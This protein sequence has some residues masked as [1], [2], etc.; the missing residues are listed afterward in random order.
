MCCRLVARALAALLPSAKPVGWR[1]AGTRGASG[2]ERA[3]SADLCHSMSA[4]AVS[5]GRLRA[6]MSAACCLGRVEKYRPQK[7]SEV[8][9]NDDAVQR[10]R[11]IATD[12]NMPH[13]IL[14]VGSRLRADA[15][16]SVAALFLALRLDQQTAA[17]GSDSGGP[18]RA[19]RASE[20]RRVSWR[21][22]AKC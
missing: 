21:W 5:D 10:L 19:R 8:V 18:H 2:Q 4:E 1:A 11:S 22:R 12:G 3:R 15:V 9:G 13:M 7:L 20:R 16:L 17:S 14:T 6:A